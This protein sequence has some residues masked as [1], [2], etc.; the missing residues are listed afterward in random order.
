MHFFPEGELDH[1]NQQPNDFHDGVFYLAER[2]D[3]PV[4]PVTL[5]IQD[6]L[7]FGRPLRKPLIQVTVEIGSP[8]LPE[9]SRGAGR[10]ASAHRMAMVARKQMVASIQSAQ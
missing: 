10:K 5:V 6:R 3:V 4:V 7:L 2:F 1:Y 8:I 9:P